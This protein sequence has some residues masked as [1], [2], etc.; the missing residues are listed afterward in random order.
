MQMLSD[1]AG[2]ED[3][4]PSQGHVITRSAIAPLMRFRQFQTPPLSGEGFA[5]FRWTCYRIEGGASELHSWRCRSCRQM[6]ESMQVYGANS[7]RCAK[8]QFLPGTTT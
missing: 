6:W 7:S 8:V 1:N 2:F 3:F 4:R 5:F